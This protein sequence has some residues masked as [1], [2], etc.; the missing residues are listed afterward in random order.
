MWEFLN[1][2][3][4]GKVPFPD[5]EKRV[6]SYG[7]YRQDTLPELMVVLYYRAVKEKNPEASFKKCVEDSIEAINKKD[8]VRKKLVG[9]GQLSR[10]QAIR[11]IYME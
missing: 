8:K 7:A 3:L 6:M 4:K 10:Q 5:F 11:Y 1:K 9:A 2:R